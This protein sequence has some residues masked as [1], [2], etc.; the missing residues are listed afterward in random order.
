M[1]IIDLIPFL[2]A[3]FSII[4]TIRKVISAGK[5]DEFLYNIITKKLPKMTKL[6]LAAEIADISY[7]LANF[8]K[9]DLAD[10]TLDGVSALKS[11]LKRYNVKVNPILPSKQ[12]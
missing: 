3:L 9:D 7:Q 4:T 11:F 8:I 5:V 10:G 12:E 6:V 2:V 1:G